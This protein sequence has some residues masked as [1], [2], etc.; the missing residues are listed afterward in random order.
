MNKFIAQKEAVRYAVEVLPNPFIMLGD[1][2]LADVIMGIRRYGYEITRFRMV[3]EDH[4]VVAYNKRN[5]RPI[6]AIGETQNDAIRTLA[7]RI[8]RRGKNA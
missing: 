3:G 2:N 4:M 5:D 1:D 7:K 6:A 8:E